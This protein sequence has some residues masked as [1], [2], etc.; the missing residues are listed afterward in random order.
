MN[1]MILDLLES[2]DSTFKQQLVDTCPRKVFSID[3]VS[4]RVL[5]MSE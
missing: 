5:K 2:K 3:P 4:Q 1:S